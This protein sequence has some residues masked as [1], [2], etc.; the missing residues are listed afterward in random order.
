MT[1]LKTQFTK[2]LMKK[3]NI[4]LF[5]YV[6]FFCELVIMELIFLLSGL[7]SDPGVLSKILNQY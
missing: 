1:S 7:K 2:F 3:Q 4:L 6:S 5:S